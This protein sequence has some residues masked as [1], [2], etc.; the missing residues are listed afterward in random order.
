MFEQMSPWFGNVV[1]GE[2]S[3][4]A[5]V[6]FYPITSVNEKTKIKLCEYAD[7]HSLKHPTVDHSTDLI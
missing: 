3:L 4:C 1:W 6:P 2:L 7:L 5:M